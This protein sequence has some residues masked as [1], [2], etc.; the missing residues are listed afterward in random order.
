MSNINH[1][2]LLQAYSR[3]S[4]RAGSHALCEHGAVMHVTGSHRTWWCLAMLMRCIMLCIVTST[5]VTAEEYA[6]DCCTSTVNSS[7][8]RKSRPLLSLANSA[9]ISVGAR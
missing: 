7:R 4:C 2:L 5:G 3:G 8:N 6:L 1:T 9:L